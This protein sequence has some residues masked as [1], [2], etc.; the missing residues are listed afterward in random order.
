MIKKKWIPGLVV[1]GTSLVAGCAMHTAAPP[2]EQFDHVV[3]AISDL[4]K[5]IEQLGEVCGVTP[6]PG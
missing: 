4:E 2:A 3:L 5:G 6:A 1:M